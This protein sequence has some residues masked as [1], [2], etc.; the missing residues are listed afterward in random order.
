ME[1]NAQIWPWG[2]ASQQCA[3]CREAA[4]GFNKEQ[5]WNRWWQNMQNKIIVSGALLCDSKCTGLLMYRIEH[6]FIVVQTCSFLFFFFLEIVG[7]MQWPRSIC[8]NIWY[9]ILLVEVFS[10]ILLFSGGWQI[11]LS[12]N[13]HL[14]NF[15]LTYSNI[16]VPLSRLQYTWE[17]NSCG[18]CHHAK[19]THKHR[20]VG[21]SIVGDHLDPRLMTLAMAWHMP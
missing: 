13:L 2:V 19:G 12:W 18:A 20:R 15:H 6:C 7:Y 16:P 9:V 5:L 3:R 17:L 21:H 4:L 11:F 10:S 14:A 1:P 8:V